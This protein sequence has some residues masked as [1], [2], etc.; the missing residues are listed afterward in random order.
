M[1]KLLNIKKRRMKDIYDVIY[2][3]YVLNG[4]NEHIGIIFYDDDI[5]SYLFILDG[6]MEGITGEC[7]KEICNY[8]DKLESE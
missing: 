6:A 8:I 7:M 3:E 4:F 5:E 1:I 2:S